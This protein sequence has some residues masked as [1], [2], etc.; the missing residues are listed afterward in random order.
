MGT[1]NVAEAV[2][3]DIEH[4]KQNAPAFEN[5]VESFRDLLVQQARLKAELPLPGVPHSFKPDPEGFS[6][7][8]SL[9]M[10]A[11]LMQAEGY[12]ETAADR[13][14]PAMEEGFP[15]I[16]PA[17]RALRTA[18]GEGKFAP[19]R[20]LQAMLKR[21]ERAVSEP[22]AQ[23]RISPALLGFVVVSTM[24]PFMEKLAEALV[25]LIEGLPWHKGNCPVCG[26]CP[27]LSFLKTN[28]GQ[29]W[30]RCSVCAHTW[31]FIRTQCPWCDNADQ[32]KT[33]AVFIEG[34][35]GERAELC[36][37]C[38]HYIVTVDLRGRSEEVISAAAVFGLLHLDVIAQGKGYAPMA[39][40][41]W[42]V[43]G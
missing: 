9:L 28:E 6:R 32:E 43:M 33:E 27:D 13:L 5:I 29:R 15:K 14:F 26:A 34:R 2:L 3:S 40:A 11:D 19:E 10:Q 38:K 18:I 17:L 7:G 12:A 20:I 30:L 31:R 8:V 4:I 42:N 25:P 16:A 41:A 36:R 23:A 21:D 24:K 22:A 37:H 35:P 39:A 1:Q